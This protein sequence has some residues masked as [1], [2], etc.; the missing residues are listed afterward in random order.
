MKA[1][2]L[3]EKSVEELQKELIELRKEQL[4]LKLQ[5]GMSEAPKPHL[6][7]QVRRNIARLKTILTQKERV[8]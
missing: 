2:E 4:S 7:T 3:L 1:K 6:H 5:R 8:A